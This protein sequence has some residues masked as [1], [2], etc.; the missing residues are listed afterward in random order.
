MRQ[1]P[2]STGRS[3][4]GKTR[5]SSA[6]RHVHRFAVG[7]SR[8]S[9]LRLAVSP[10]AP[11]HEGACF[12]VMPDRRTNR[13]NG[14]LRRLL[15]GLDAVGRAKEL[16]QPDVAE[17]WRDHDVGWIADEARARNSILDQRE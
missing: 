17:L 3:K 16:E 11:G 9:L 5:F 8:H 1:L 15:T 12:G 14:S 6:E 4:T 2:F 13:G 10:S 7:A